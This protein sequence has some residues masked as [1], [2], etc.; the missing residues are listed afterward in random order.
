M[1]WPTPTCPSH[2]VP[3][4]AHPFHHVRDHFVPAHLS[5]TW[6]GDLKSTL[7]RLPPLTLTAALQAGH[8]VIGEGFGVGGRALDV[9][10]CSS[11]EQREAQGVEVEGGVLGHRRWNTG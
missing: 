6:D 3:I 4:R 8:E 2:P 1:S 7:P 11:A 10:G 5:L 9:R